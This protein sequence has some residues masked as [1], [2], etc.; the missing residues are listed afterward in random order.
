MKIKSILVLI[1]LSQ[2]IFVF[3]QRSEERKEKKEQIEIAR[4]GYLTSAVQLTEL[5]ANEFWPV[6]NEYSQKRKQLKRQARQ[7]LKNKELDA[8]TDAEAKELLQKLNSLH[9]QEFQLNKTYEPKLLQIV[10]S[11]QLLQLMKAEREF[12][13]ML[14]KK[15]SGQENHQGAPRETDNID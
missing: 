10:S 14:H 1:F 5:Q 7:L 2:A 9:E 12:I 15:A 13:R 3:A 4:I 11:K 8:I 6:Y